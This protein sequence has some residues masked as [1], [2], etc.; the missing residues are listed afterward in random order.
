M[1]RPEPT[2]PPGCASCARSRR[3]AGPPPAEPSPLMAR[4]SLSRRL[5]VIDVPLAWLR[6]AGREA[7]G[8]VNDAFLAALVGGLRIYHERRRR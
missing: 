5:A 3:L 7:G 1:L 2:I 4:R 8:S 6:A